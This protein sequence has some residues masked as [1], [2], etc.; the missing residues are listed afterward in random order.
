MVSN[1]N[2]LFQGFI[3]RFHVS[4]PGCITWIYIVLHCNIH[5]RQDPA[6]WS[7]FLGKKH[8][9]NEKATA[10]SWEIWT[11]TT[12]GGCHS[13]IFLYLHLEKWGNDPIW[14]YSMF[15]LS[16]FNYQLGNMKSILLNSPGSFTLLIEGIL[17]HGFSMAVH[18]GKS[19]DI[20]Y[21]INWLR[22]IVFGQ[23][24]PH[25]SVQRLFRKG[26][27]Y[28]YNDNS[29]QIFFH[30]LWIIVLCSFLPRSF[31]IQ[32]P[33]SN[34]YQLV[35]LTLPSNNGGRCR[36]EVHFRDGQFEGTSSED[37]W[38]LFDI[39]VPDLGNP[40]RWTAGSPTAIPHE[41]KGTWSSTKPP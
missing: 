41:K 31:W 14:Q 7:K 16:W 26:C 39:L 6:S 3:C 33:N 13:H 2:L 28:L 20:F 34:S 8:R 11:V 29:A 21:D 4:F 1:R 27:N 22:R 15:Q 40:G 36:R 19:W 37:A 12:L 17:H 23:E 24:A 25:P 10:K 9:K 18:N 30:V 35:I 32:L 5:R 38:I